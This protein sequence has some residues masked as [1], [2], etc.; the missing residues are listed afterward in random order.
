MTDNGVDPIAFAGGTTVHSACEKIAQTM[1]VLAHPAR[2]QMLVR[3]SQQERPVAWLAEDTNIQ[4]HAASSHLRLM[5]REGIVKGIRRGK[6][7]CY[8][9]SDTKVRKLIHSLQPWLN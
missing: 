9:I 8:R 4:P 1:R 5:Q 6:F 7:V 3:L 2:L